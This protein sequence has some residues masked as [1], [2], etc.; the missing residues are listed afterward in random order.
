MRMACAAKSIRLARRKNNL[1]AFIA[2]LSLALLHREIGAYRRASR[3]VQSGAAR[4]IAAIVIPSH[5]ET[6]GGDFLPA[7]DA[8]SLYCGVRALI[9]LLAYFEII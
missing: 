9:Y 7:R 4:N 8:E 1:L 3:N 5:S 2:R 6:K